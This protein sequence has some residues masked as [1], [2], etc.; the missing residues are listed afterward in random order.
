MTFIFII[1]IVILGVVLYKLLSQ[2]EKTYAYTSTM[3]ITYKPDGT[4]QLSKL[5][6]SG[7]IFIARKTVT[8][9]GEPYFYKSSDRKKVQA[10][11]NYDGGTLKSISLSLPDEGE[12]FYYV[13]KIS[14]V[15]DIVRH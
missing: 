3:T 15:K 14:S 13:D 1:A 12:K 10:R 4:E 9:D 6:E 7:I 2:S 8:I 11:L 5:E